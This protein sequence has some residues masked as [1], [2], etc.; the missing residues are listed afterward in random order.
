MYIMPTLPLS[1][2]SGVK[3][4]PVFNT[5]KQK[6]AAGIT[7]AIALM[8]YPCWAFEVSLEHVMGNEALATSIVAQFLGAYMATAGGA[9]LW[10]FTDPQS[11]SVAN[12]QFGVGNGTST[13]FQLSRNIYGQPDIIQKLN[14]APAIYV[15]GIHNATASV[16]STGVVTFTTPP[17]S[18]AVL[19]WTGFYFYAVRF[20]EDT[21]DAIREFTTNNGNDLW[22]F[23]GL[24]FQSEF[25]PTST[26][27]IIA[28]P[29]G[30]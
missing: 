20:S 23:N 5:L 16:S 24:K 26:Y 25:V 27:G 2:S 14:G 21:L 22:S 4:S 28:S 9:A 13:A 18:G 11:N 17:A 3:K 8:P 29:G 12:A 6:S 1:M 19:T 30:A 15:G 7:S 10:L